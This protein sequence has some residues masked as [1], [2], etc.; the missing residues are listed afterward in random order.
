MANLNVTYEDMKTAAAQLIQGKE[1]ITAKLSEL[2]QLIDNLVASGYVT[3]QSS[4]AFDQT[5]DQFITGT[6][7]GIEALDGLSKYLVAAA[8]AMQSTDEGLAQSIQS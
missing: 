3:D 1:D 2:N 7:T 8:D 6:K 5:F 4:R